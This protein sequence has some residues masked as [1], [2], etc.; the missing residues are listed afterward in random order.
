LLRDDCWRE[1]IR[2]AAGSTVFSY[3]RTTEDF[4]HELLDLAND[5]Q[6]DPVAR[7]AGYRLAAENL[8]DVGHSG[9]LL[10]KALQTQ[11]TTGLAARLIE[12]AIAA[13][14][15]NLLPERVAAAEALGRLGD[16]REGVTTLPP[17]L[18]AVIQGR[19][20]YGEENEERPT[21]PFQA[22]VYPVT[23]AQFEPFWQAGGYDQPQWWSE[24][25]WWWRQEK[26]A[27]DWQKTDQPDFWDDDRFNN[28]NQPVVGVTWYEA[29]G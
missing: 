15:A 22:G 2:L 20:Q 23:N 10:E 12:P 5:P 29:E 19:F 27:Y 7:L 18:T 25:G 28:P 21:A 1:P 24:A 14:A 3:S 16:P 17:L 9:R 6:A 4:L 11:I 8:V 26:P 13:P